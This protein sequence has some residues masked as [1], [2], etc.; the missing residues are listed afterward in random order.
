MRP[1]PIT[2]LKMPNCKLSAPWFSVKTPTSY[3]AFF[4]GETLQDIR[5]IYLSFK[6]GPRELKQDIPVSVLT[7]GRLT[8]AG[9]YSLKTKGCL[10]LLAPGEQILYYSLFRDPHLF[11][12]KISQARNTFFSLI[13]LAHQHFLVRP[14]FCV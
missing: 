1:L 5:L 9:T 6:E 8:W 11:P 4:S 12:T 14:L 2:K 10:I 13:N 3:G 7:S